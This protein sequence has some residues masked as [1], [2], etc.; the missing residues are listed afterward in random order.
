MSEIAVHCSCSYSVALFP[1]LLY[2]HSPLNR[3][4][5]DVLCNFNVLLTF[6]FVYILSYGFCVFSRGMRRAI[7]AKKQQLL[8]C[9]ID[10]FGSLPG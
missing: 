5:Y 4:K 1:K 9:E 6:F 8:H 2:V 10:D 7:S 3:Y